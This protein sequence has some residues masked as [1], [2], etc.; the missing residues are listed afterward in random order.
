M[1]V[2]VSFAVPLRVTRARGII[3][4]ATLAA[5]SRTPSEGKSGGVDG[6]REA[7]APVS[8]CATESVAVSAVHVARGVTY[9]TRDRPLQFDVAWS[10]QGPPAP[11]ILLLHGGGWSGG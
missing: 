5:C 7:V 3:A 11:L 2:Q 8:R 4:A 6:A 9:V 1:S 10:E